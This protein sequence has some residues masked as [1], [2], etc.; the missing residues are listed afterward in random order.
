MTATARAPLKRRTQEERRAQTRAKLLD[1]TIQSLLDVGYAGTTTRRVSEAAGV[2]PGAQSHHFPHRVDLVT[3]AAEHL[4]ELRLQ[5]LKRH[6]DL[7]PSD[8]QARSTA[9]LNLMWR[10]FSSPVFQ[11]F[12]KL[13]IAAADDRELYNRLIP[14]ERRLSREISQLIPTLTGTGETP[15]DMRSRVLLALAALRGLAL[16]WSFEPT[17][18]QHKDPWPSLR[19]HLARLFLAD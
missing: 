10:D 19:P 14:L 12:V 18:R 9:V 2:S 16:T 5:E 8:R 3:A 7:L 11:V 4:V 17:A 6:A 1:A 15:S 13:W